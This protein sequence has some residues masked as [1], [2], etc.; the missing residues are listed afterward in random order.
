MH[1]RLHAFLDAVLAD[2]DTRA[3]ESAIALREVGDEAMPALRDVLADPDPDRRW[4][5]GRALAAVGTDAAIE[6]LITALEDLDPDVRA[7][8]VVA[9]SKLKPREAIGPLVARLSDPSAYVGRLTADALA[10]YGQ[11]AV[12]ALINALEEGET[13]AR[14]GAARALSAIRPEEAIPALY[15]ALDDP[16]ALVSYYAEEALEKMGV[17]IILFR[18]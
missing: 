7:C 11:P 5:A 15:R 17:G 18:P 6:L 4:W 8:A 12:E 2:D 16:S 13:A 14:A 9:L 1:D 10:Q 3:E